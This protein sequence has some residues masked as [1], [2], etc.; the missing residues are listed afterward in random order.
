M[1][2]EFSWWIESFMR[3]FLESDLPALGIQASEPALRRFWT[4]LAHRHRQI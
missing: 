3:M 1:T 4:T 2:A